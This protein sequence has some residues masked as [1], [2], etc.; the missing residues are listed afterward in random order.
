[1]GPG[2]ATTLTVCNMFVGLLLL[3]GNKLSYFSFPQVH[4]G[5]KLAPE[6][7]FN[8]VQLFRGRKMAPREGK[9]CR[10]DVNILLPIGLK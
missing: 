8:C 9:P 2:C 1:M 5:Q 4:F 10:F 6:T 7:K 3:S